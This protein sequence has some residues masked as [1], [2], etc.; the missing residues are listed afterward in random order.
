[1]TVPNAHRQHPKVQRHFSLAQNS[2][3]LSSFPN[4]LTPPLPNENDELENEM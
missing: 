1:M 3:N 4:F 2:L